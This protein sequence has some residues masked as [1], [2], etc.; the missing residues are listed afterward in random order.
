[1]SKKKAPKPCAAC[2]ETTSAPGGAHY[3]RA[4][5][6][7]VAAGEIKKATTIEA[8]YALEDRYVLIDEIHVDDRTKIRAAIT[9]RM[10][11]LNPAGEPTQ[12]DT[13]RLE[14]FTDAIRKA[15]TAAQLIAIEER[16]R[17]GF[18]LEGVRTNLLRKVG[19]RR[20]E[21]EREETARAAAVGAG[22]AIEEL[23]G[24][25]K[26]WSKE[27][28]DALEQG[29]TPAT[30]IGNMI[31]P[32]PAEEEDTLYGMTEGQLIDAVARHPRKEIAHLAANAKFKAAGG[33]M[34]YIRKNTDR[35]LHRYLFNA[36][37]LRIFGVKMIKTT[38]SMHWSARVA[39]L[40]TIRDLH[41]Y[42]RLRLIYSPLDHFKAMDDLDRDES[43]L[44]ATPKLIGHADALEALQKKRADAQLEFVREQERCPEIV[45]SLEVMQTQYK[46]QWT[47][48][49]FLLTA[50]DVNRLND[51][52]Q[53]LGKYQ[54]LLKPVLVYADGELS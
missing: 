52:L 5:V 24:D 4:H 48:I 26:P 43:I 44:K 3:C 11:Q 32:P 16:I 8:V 21:A 18:F 13:Q 12:A 7:E 17:R 46:K 14:F 42:Y 28:V 22:K 34:R 33:F 35:G 51:H 20:V 39:F 27:D 50:E 15:D 47:I 38:A 40:G 6:V 30:K 49:T 2:G 29:R 10:R 45:L 53:D 23:K 1:M 36:A 25:P 54:V 31:I 9:R 19:D 37:G 41:Q